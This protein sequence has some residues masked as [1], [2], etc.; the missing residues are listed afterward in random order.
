MSI[1]NEFEGLHAWIGRSEEVH[2]QIATTPISALAATLDIEIPG[3]TEHLLLPPCWHWLYFLPVDRQST[4]G[5][6]GH[7]MRGGFLPP[8]H[9]PRRMWAGS[10]LIF[11]AP[12]HVGR[13][14]SKVSRISDVKV[15]EGRTGSLVF[16][17]VQHTI[18][19]GGQ[20]CIREIQD[21]VYR[22]MPS[23]QEANQ[24]PPPVLPTFDWC[25]EIVPDA[26][27]L[28]RYSALT[29]N[30]HR[31]HYDRPYATGTE[32]YPGLVVHGPLVATLLL[33]LLNREIPHSRVISF[34]F[35]AKKPLFD[36]APFRVC[37][38]IQENNVVSL[39]AINSSDE[40]AMEATANIALN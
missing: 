16:V 14:I 35:R 30:A 26:V 32:G 39:W 6:D 2:D 28:F 15:K 12:L 36:T 33:D 22:E 5:I 40:I 38:R 9:L 34:T 4:I 19:S 1:N 11:E 24:L 29:F 20:A 7:P 3:P 27:L 37:G 21:I 31:I 18:F 10:R 13:R 8:V 23:G 25:R 17:S